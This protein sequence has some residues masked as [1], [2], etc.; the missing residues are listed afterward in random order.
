M[1]YLAVLLW[2]TDTSCV[3]DLVWRKFCLISENY[4]IVPLFVRGK[5]LRNFT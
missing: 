1:I 3:H 2:D 5:P 4:N